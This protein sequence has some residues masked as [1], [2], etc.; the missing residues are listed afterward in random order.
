MS[1]TRALTRGELRLAGFHQVI[2][3]SSALA[4][5]CLMGASITALFW[6]AGVIGLPLAAR[7]L[8][9]LAIEVMAVSL[10]ASAT[11]AY[12]DGG[13]V[14]WSAWVGFGFFISIAAFANVLHALTFL[15]ESAAPGWLSPTSFAVAACVFAAACPLG[16]TWG[17][18]RFGWLRAHGAD[19]QW[20]ADT[21]QRVDVA[22]TPRAPR[23]SAAKRAP[24]TARATTP[25]RA[26]ARAGQPDASPALRRA[27]SLYDA[28]VDVRPGKPQAS[29]IHDEIQGFEGA[30]QTPQTTRKWVA[31]WWAEDARNPDTRGAVE[32]TMLRS[33]DGADSGA[34]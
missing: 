3:Y 27:R 4:A 15:D 11:T 26:V 34:A 31:G 9:A 5:L 12:R 19:A 23:A 32:P 1:R 29:V 2:G 8:V 30:P 13:K 24:Q 18:H 33:A 17:V 14:D 16:G 21:G 25:P 6:F 28:A 7:V 20:G 22:P 10:A